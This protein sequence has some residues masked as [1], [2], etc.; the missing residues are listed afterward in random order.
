MSS[1]LI[2]RDPE[3]IKLVLARDF[4]YFNSTTFFE[5]AKYT[6]KRNYS[7][8]YLYISYIYVN[9][10]CNPVFISENLSP[11]TKRLH[12]ITTDYAKSNGFKYCWVTNGKIFLRRQDGTG[13]ILIK[14]E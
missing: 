3:Y 10:P 4:Y 6:S 14:N 5:I 1:T 13:L 12:Y 7:S 9:G 8:K 11:Q 2:L